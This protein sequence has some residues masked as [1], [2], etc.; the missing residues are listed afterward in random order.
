MTQ[1]DDDSAGRSWGVRHVAIAIVGLLLLAALLSMIFPALQAC[2][3]RLATTGSAGVV[4][5]CEPIFSELSTLGLAILLVVLVLLPLLSKFDVA[6]LVS[7]EMKADAA[8][9]DAEEARALAEAVSRQS[10]ELEK[11]QHE[12][13]DIQ[14]RLLARSVADPTDVAWSR[15]VQTITPAQGPP[16]EQIASDTDTAIKRLLRAADDLSLYERMGPSGRARDTAETPVAVTAAGLKAVVDWRRRYQLELAQVRAVRNRV[17][18]GE[19]TDLDEVVRAADL[20][21]RLLA[22]VRDAINSVE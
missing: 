14:D 6:G 8:K 3:D 21:E 18:H 2:H 5:V 20:A 4:Q 19:D 1:Q 10:A 17:A 7:I 15:W 9:K 22:V 13:S 16:R 11:V 12:L